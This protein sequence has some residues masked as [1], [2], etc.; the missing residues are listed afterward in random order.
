MAAAARASYTQSDLLTRQM[1]S[2]GQRTEYWL[3]AK[4]RKKP[5]DR[6]EPYCHVVY[7]GR[8]TVPIERRVVRRIIVA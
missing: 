7:R 6:L 2:S 5:E 8:H 3:T 1:D 4:D